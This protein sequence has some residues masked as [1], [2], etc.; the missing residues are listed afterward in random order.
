LL[1]ERLGRWCAAGAGLPCAEI[2]RLDGEEIEQVD[3]DA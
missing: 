3:P 1:L 2:Y